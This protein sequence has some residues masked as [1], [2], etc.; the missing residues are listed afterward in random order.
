MNKFEQVFSL[1]HQV[2]LPGGQGPGP[3]Q[4]GR[5]PCTEGS[6]GQGVVVRR[7]GGLCMVR[8]KAT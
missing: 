8:S 1:G 6:W 4:G 5:G 2:S 7:G 3:G